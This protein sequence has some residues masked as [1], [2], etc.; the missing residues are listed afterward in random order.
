MFEDQ[1]TIPIIVAAAA[2]DSINPCVFGVLI[3]L[4]TFLMA[5]F[6]SPR[7]MLLGG[8]VYA[9]A[10]YIT[11]F[12]LGLGILYLTVGV[13][14]ARFVYWTAAIIAILAGLLEIKDY[15]WYGRWFT[16]EMIPG[17]SV[18]IKRYTEMIRSL[19]RRSPW[20]S[21]AMAAFLGFF[22]P[23]V[24]L[25]CTGAPYFAILALIARGAYD[26]AV[27]YLLLYNFVFVVP[28]FFIIGLVYVGKSGESLE[29]WRKDH[30]RL[31][32]LLTGIF[33]IVLGGYMISVISAV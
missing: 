5:V 13:G 24:E 21:Y 12:L 25:P 29:A 8:L 32:R 27:P 4:L 17:A 14:L 6:K 26:K 7:R 2:L 20:L 10:V 33:L 3:F 16:L 1:L 18:R 15:F 28:L 22:V 19:D 30:R 9:S 11:Y 23:M 31:M